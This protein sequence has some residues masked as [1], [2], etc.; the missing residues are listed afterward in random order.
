MQMVLP[1]GI[2]TLQHMCTKKYSRPDNVFST[3]GLQDYIVKCEVDP[4]LKPTSTDHFPVLTYIQLPQERVNAPPSF[5]FREMDWE[6]FRRKL[7]PRLRRSSDKPIITDVAQLN[8]AVEDLTQAL[9]ETIQE[10]VKRSKPRPDSKRWWNGDLIKMRKALYRLR[11][12]SYRF[13]AFADHPSHSELKIESNKYGEPIIQA[14]R[15]HW[16][17]YLEEMSANEIWTANKYIREPVGDGGNPRILT[18]KVKNVAGAETSISSNEE[19][20]KTFVKLFFPPPPLIVDEYDDFKYPEPLPDPPQ[21]TPE[22]LFRHVSKP[23]PYKA[24]GL[25]DIPNVVLQQCVALIHE[26]LIRIFQAI[27]NLNLYYNPWR[28]FTTVVLRK[29]GKPSYLVPKAYRPIALLSTMAKVLTSLVA[30][31]I[32]NLVETHQLLPKTRFGG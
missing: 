16:T 28:E 13:R 9:Q 29:P 27:L 23:S 3:P 2:P 21:I 30:E 5:N 12:D 6:E 32:S 22:Q 4:A 19:K 18:L 11:A 1:K 31:V 24:F 25:D 7:E 10:V 26:R 17:N 15:S 14:R 8:T 20:A